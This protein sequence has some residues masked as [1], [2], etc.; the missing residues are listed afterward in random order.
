MRPD[1]LPPKAAA[2]IL[3][4]LL[5]LAGCNVGDPY[6]RPEIATPA[7]WR[8]A[9]AIG[10]VNG[11]P[12][13]GPQTQ[14][15]AQDWW[16][17]FEAPQLSAFMAQAYRA[18]QDLAAAIARVRQ[19]DATV[20]IS[21]AALLPAVN[22][23]GG[24]NRSHTPVLSPKAG[25]SNSASQS[26]LYTAN[27]TA[28][29]EIDFW[30]KNAATRDAAV[31]SARASRAAQAVVSLTLQ[32]SVATDYFTAIALQDR[33]EIAR[34]TLAN[35]QEVEA[36]I[37]DRLQRGTATELDLTQQQ[38]LTETARAAIPP[39]EEQW[40]QT[41][42]AL[43]I[44]AGRLPEDVAAEE[45]A[46][47]SNLLDQ[48]A[49]PEV[50]AGLPS[51]LLTRRPDI[52]EAEEQLVA[53]NANVTAARAALF[54]SITL[55]GEGGFESLRLPTLLNAA[56]S[57]FTLGANA[58]QP[59]FRGGALTGAEEQLRGRQEELVATYRKTVLTAF[60]DVENAL[61]AY[62]KTTEQ[63]TSQ[64]RAAK[65]AQQSYDLALDQFRGGLVD[66]TTVLSTQKSLFTAQ[67]SLAQ[68]KLARLE[69]IISL[70]TALGGGWDPA[71][72]QKQPS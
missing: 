25:S 64:A 72:I 55:T 6:Q 39:L 49:I 45:I 1:R 5:T 9:T 71:T 43:A 44:L 4:P 51:E 59:I 66:I 53:A 56:H 60:G 2:L 52:R 36:A 19:A 28:S 14:W 40:Q 58:A 11:S 15:P 34:R 69:S 63:Q 22:A 57:L 26:T 23:G 47:G 37:T 46:A 7:D 50:L 12:I 18:N 68:V 38:T 10:P 29:Y 32:T 67:D 70:Y 30:G 61:I 41:L 65:L 35:A 3:L 33:L 54:P 48:V 24:D 20:Q 16:T 31:A 13:V 62:R 42:N 21:G 8:E 17:R 27:L